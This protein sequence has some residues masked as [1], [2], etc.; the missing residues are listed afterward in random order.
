MPNTQTAAAPTISIDDFMTGFLASLAKKGVKSVSLR[1]AFYA[2]LRVA[3]REF[4]DEATQRGHEVDFIV[5]THP[6]HGDSPLVRMAI[7]QAVQR[8]LISLDN[9]VYLDMRLKIGRSYAQEYI[10]ALP[11]GPDLYDDMTRK[12][13][14]EFEVR[15]GA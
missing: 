9:P 15:T 3:F 5:N 10:D 1:D 6:V 4:R 14:E 7:T 8:D 11:G 2:S 12:F 13:L